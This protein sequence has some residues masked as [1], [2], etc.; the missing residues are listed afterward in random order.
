MTHTMNRLGWG[1]AQCT[2]PRRLMI[3]QCVI[4]RALH[5]VFPSHPIRSPVT[6]SGFFEPLNDEE[7]QKV[8][9]LKAAVADL[10]QV[11]VNAP[12][13]PRARRA[14]RPRTLTSGTDFADR[15]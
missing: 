3:V 4:I 2:Q 7:Q 10:V 5:S 12:Q 13:G 9:Q 14:V 15:S 1:D 8:Q 11:R 6:M